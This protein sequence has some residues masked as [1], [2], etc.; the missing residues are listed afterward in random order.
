MVKLWN[1]NIILSIINNHIC[2]I[3]SYT[4]IWISWEKGNYKNPTQ[5]RCV[6]EFWL[7]SNKSRVKYDILVLFQN[8]TSNVK[9]LVTTWL[10]HPYPLSCN[11]IS[12]QFHFQSWMR[13]NSNTEIGLTGWSLIIILDG[14]NIFIE[15][16]K[17]WSWSFLLTLF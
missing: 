12:F 6:F 11:K 4:I 2:F 1:G 15:L 3:K 8:F 16:I 9:T 5:S 14:F 13:R 17:V 7:Y 10:F